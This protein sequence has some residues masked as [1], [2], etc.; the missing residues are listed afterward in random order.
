[1]AH[2][3][4]ALFQSVYKPAEG[5]LTSLPLM[6]EWYLIT[7]FLGIVASLGILWSPLLWLWP[8]GAAFC[9]SSFY[10]GYYKLV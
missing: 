1:M 6:P 8:F 4:S 9:N 7:F 5:F 2:G 3:G 10:S